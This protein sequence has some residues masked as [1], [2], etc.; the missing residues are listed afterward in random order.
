MLDEARAA[1]AA[2][3]IPTVSHAIAVGGSATSTARI[4]G[5]RIDALLV[6]E[7]LGRLCAG[8]SE[9]VGLEHGLDPERVRLLPAGLH[10]LEAAG[11]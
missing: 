3:D 11:L 6:A 10:L 5:P 8:P 1:F 4:V 7:A 2:L 9:A